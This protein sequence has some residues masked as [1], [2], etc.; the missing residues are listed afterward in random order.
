M[1]LSGKRCC[2]VTVAPSPVLER[3]PQH[4]F[5]LFQYCRS[6]LQG[7]APHHDDVEL[8]VVQTHGSKQWKLYQPI[9]AYQ[10]PNQ[11]SGDL[12]QVRARTAALLDTWPAS[13]GLPQLVWHLQ[14][15]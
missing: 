4:L 14:Q 5:L 6:A 8:W 1:L 3:K 2:R 12:D 13:A 10:L 7:L 9:N 11:P 15:R